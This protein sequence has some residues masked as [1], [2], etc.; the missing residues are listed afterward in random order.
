[1]QTNALKAFFVIG[2]IFCFISG[3]PVLAGEKTESHHFDDP[4]GNWQVRTV[5]SDI[6]THGLEIRDGKTNS[7]LCTFTPGGVMFVS[8]YELVQFKKYPRDL[9]IAQWTGIH[10]FMIAVLDPSNKDHCNLKFFENNDEQD[11][12]IDENR[13]RITVTNFHK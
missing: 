13:D 2:F 6:G 11:Y 3:A 5:I 1:M 7:I 10:S 4:V 8:Q 9:L 12:K